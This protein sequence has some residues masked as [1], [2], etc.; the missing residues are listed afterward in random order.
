MILRK[1][2][3]YKVVEIIE[4]NDCKDHINMLVIINPKLIVATFMG[5]FK[6]KGSLMIFDRYAHMKY[7]YGNR[8]F[9]FIIT[10]ILM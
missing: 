10:N 3:E 5:Y 7:E 8:S 6:G 9:G 1:L 2:C 4:A